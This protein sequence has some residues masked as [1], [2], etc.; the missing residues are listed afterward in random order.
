MSDHSNC[1]HTYI[2]A[3]VFHDVYQAHDDD[4]DDFVVLG[5][6]QLDDDDNRLF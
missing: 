1:L 2:H 4:D 5:S 3:N 6:D